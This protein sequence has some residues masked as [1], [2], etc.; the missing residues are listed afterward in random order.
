MAVIKSSKH[1]EDHLHEFETNLNSIINN[2]HFAKDSASKRF[3]SI[4]KTE[5]EDLK[6]IQLAL[7]VWRIFS[8]KYQKSPSH[9]TNNNTEGCMP[10]SSTAQISQHITKVKGEKICSR[11]LK[12]SH[13]DN[14]FFIPVAIQ[15]QDY[16]RSCFAVVLT[17]LKYLTFLISMTI[18]VS[19]FLALHKPT[20]VFLSRN[21]QNLIYPFMRTARLLTLPIVQRFPKVTGL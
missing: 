21:S 12:S 9:T 5:N 13:P 18:L 3:R 4:R 10:Q 15:G 2:H 20:Q 6:D 19:L 7:K 11:D 14:R 8:S 17:F 1:E 16:L